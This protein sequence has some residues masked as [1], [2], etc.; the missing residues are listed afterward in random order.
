[1][2]KLT[3]RK[4]KEYILLNLSSKYNLCPGATTVEIICRNAISFQLSSSESSTPH[5]DGYLLFGT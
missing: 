4:L 3:A 1:M 5:C 2:R